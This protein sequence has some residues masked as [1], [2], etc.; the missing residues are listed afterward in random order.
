MRRQHEEYLKNCKEVKVCSTELCYSSF[1]LAKHVREEGAL[2][3]PGPNT[4]K[5]FWWLSK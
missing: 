2:L 1:D 5:L 3:Y 4:K